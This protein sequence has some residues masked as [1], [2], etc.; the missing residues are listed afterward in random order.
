MKTA[1]EAGLVVA[2]A[3]LAVTAARALIVALAT[4]PQRR[5]NRAHDWARKVDI[6]LPPELV[7][8]LAARLRSRELARLAV[9]AVLLASVSGWGVWDFASQHLPAVPHEFN[10]SGPLRL[11]GLVACAVVLPTALAHL[12][13]VGREQRRPGVRVAR[14]QPIGPGD[15]VP[16]SMTWMVRVV[17]VL[18]PVLSFALQLYVQHYGYAKNLTGYYDLVYLPV[19][20]V[21]LLAEFA[22]ERLQLSVLN[23]RQMAGSWPELAFDEAFRV[24]AA[25]S[26]LPIAPTVTYLL[27]AALLQPVYQS[28]PIGTAMSMTL[29]WP[30]LNSAWAVCGMTGFML[31][32]QSRK[33]QVHQFYRRGG[34]RPRGRRAL[35]SR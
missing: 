27:C 30:I 33:E 17:V 23:G 6:A 35:F 28:V 5:L 2:G 34:G 4:S 21:A 7:G 12:W 31:A 20:C 29:L 11:Y 16:P 15:A 13:E 19:L 3:T 26:L 1:V 22:V 18:T 8:P 10:E 24:R 32:I 25:L 14:L 9:L